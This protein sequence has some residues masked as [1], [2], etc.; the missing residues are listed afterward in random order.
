MGKSL[1]GSALVDSVSA[2]LD[3]SRVIG[4]GW[5]ALDC[6]SVDTLA[7]KLR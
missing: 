6:M 3:F 1:Q 4:L 7:H 5:V 2:Q